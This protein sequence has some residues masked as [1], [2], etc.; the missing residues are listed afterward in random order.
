MEV[1]SLDAILVSASDCN[2]NQPFATVCEQP[3]WQ[4]VV[5]PMGKVEKGIMF[6]ACFVRNGLAGLREVATMCKFLGRL[7]FCHN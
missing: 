6:I 2:R 5:V 1:C 4:K 3:S 7:A